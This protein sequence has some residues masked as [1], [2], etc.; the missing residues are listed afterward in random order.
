M[1]FVG[2]VLMGIIIRKFRILFKGEEKENK[3]I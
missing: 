3:Y 2:S 1:I